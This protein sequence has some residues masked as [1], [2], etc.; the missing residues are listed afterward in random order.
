[1]NNFN[2]NRFLNF[3]KYDL[4][5]NKAFYRNMTLVT[6]FGCLGITLL[7]FLIRWRIAKEAFAL[8]TDHINPGEIIDYGD[9]YFGEANPELLTL[10]A[11]YVLLFCLGMFTIYAGYTFHNLRNKQGRIIELTIPATNIE[12]W[13]WHILMVTVG[14]LLC[15]I[16]SV[17]CADI[18]NAILNLITYGTHIASSLTAEVCRIGLLIPNPFA[19]YN[20]WTM[21]AMFNDISSSGMANYLRLLM[22]S[23][24]FLNVSTYVFGNSVKYRYNIILTYIALQIIGFF[25][26]TFGII[27]SSYA[28][29]DWELLND[30]TYT[31][32]FAKNFAKF[33]YYSFITIVWVTGGLLLWGSYRKYCKAQITSR[34]NK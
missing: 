11:L 5:I 21:N 9:A 1:M 20:S 14:G 30:V 34:L 6:I 28:T 18:V 4:T 8:Y 15:C 10:T 32:E 13:T 2:T 3:G 22:V 23:I 19:A 7:G 12:R 33:L 29:L 31:E 24:V 26:I 25:M 16:T 17:V 27:F